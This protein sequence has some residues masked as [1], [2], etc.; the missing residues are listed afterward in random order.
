MPGHPA[1]HRTAGDVRAALVGE[2][3]AGR[4]VALVPTMGA[5]HAGHASLVDRAVAECDAVVASIFVNPLQFGPGEDLEQYPRRFDDDVA[6]LG[7]RG[8]AHVFAPEATTFA[9]PELRTT[10]S[11]RGPLAERFEGASRPGHFDGVATIVTKL[12]AVALPDRAYFGEKDLQQLAVVRTLVRDLDLP[13]DVVGC[14]IVRDVDGLALSSRNA[15]L[16]ADERGHALA[17]AAALRDA[18]ATWAGDATA[19]RRALR[20]ALEAAPCVEPDY[21]DVVDPRTF[22]ALEGRVDGPAHAVVAARVGR[23]RLIDNAVLG[24]PR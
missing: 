13:V 23:A 21:A 14:P 22:E 19:A 17:L 10:V 16:A 9:P 1:V 24:G 12:L 15:Y 7:E 4:T 3:R 6:M 11:V 20:A 5:L 18:Q 8:V 2:R